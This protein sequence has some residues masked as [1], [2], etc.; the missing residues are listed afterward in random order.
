MLNN[1]TVGG[2]LQSERNGD[3]LLR[4]NPSNYRPI[5]GQQKKHSNDAMMKNGKRNFVNPVGVN[6]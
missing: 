6:C 4:H 5:V 3:I 2:L 1:G